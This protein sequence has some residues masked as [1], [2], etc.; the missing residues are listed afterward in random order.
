MPDIGLRTLARVRQRSAVG[1]RALAST[2]AGQSFVDDALQQI[3][4][5]YRDVCGFLCRM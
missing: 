2:C 3:E 4:G 5:H 1:S